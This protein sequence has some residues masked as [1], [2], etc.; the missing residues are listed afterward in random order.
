ML[1]DDQTL[2]FERIDDARHRG[3]ADLFGSGEI[4]ESHRA[5]EDDDRESGETRRVQAAA[6]VFAAQLPQEM[7]GDGME[8]VGDSLRIV[9][10][11]FAMWE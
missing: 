10:I 8:F 9:A 4:A 5:G 3:W 2:L 7:N 11:S 1:F 6:F